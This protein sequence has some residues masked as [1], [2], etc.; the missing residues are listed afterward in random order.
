MVH[1]ERR[2][3]L[4]PRELLLVL[5]GRIRLGMGGPVEFR[6]TMNLGRP[7]HPDAVHTRVRSVSI[8]TEAVGYGDVVVRSCIMRRRV[9]GHARVSLGREVA[10]V[11]IDARGVAGGRSGVRNNSVVRS[12]GVT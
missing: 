7:R 1:D 8:G 2:L 5:L 3:P 4:G 12:W 10:R 9:R 11:A 6:T